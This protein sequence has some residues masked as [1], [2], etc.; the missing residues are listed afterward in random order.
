MSTNQSLKQKRQR[1]V[2]LTTSGL[3]KLQQARAEAEYFENLGQKYILADLSERC[4]LDSGTVSKILAAEQGVDKQTLLRLFSAFKLE[5]HTNDYCRIGLELPQKEP[6]VTNTHQ[7]WGEAPD[8]SIFYGRQE[9]LATLQ[10]WIIKERCRLVVLLGMG[11]IGK[12][13]LAV[14]LGQQLQGEFNYLIWQSLRNAPPIDDVLA[15][16]VQFLSN[17]QETAIDLPKDVSARVGRIMHYLRASRCLLVLDNAEAILQSGKRA[18]QYR[19]GYESYSEL[20]RQVG[21]VTHQSCLVLTSREKPEEITAQ[22]GE[23]L[24]VRSFQL[25]GLKETEGQQLLAAKGLAVR[26]GIEGTELVKYYSGN[27]LALKIAATSIRELFLDNI[28]AFLTQGT[29]VF[30]EIRKLLEQQFNRLSVLEEQVM[31]WM[32]IA[33]EPILLLELQEDIVLP[34][35]KA[36]LLEAIQSLLRRSLIESSLAGFSQQAVVMEYVT[37]RLVEQIYKEITSGQ[38]ESL[39]SHALIKASAKEYIRVNQVRMILEPIAGR[40]VS[41]FN[42]KKNVENQLK[43][44]LSKLRKQFATSP[45]YGGGNLINLLSQLEIDLS[46]YDFS[47]LS[48]WQAYLANLNLHQVNFAYADLAKSIFAETFG[49]VLSI[50]LSSDGKLLASGD[51]CGEIHLW[52]VIDGQKLFTWKGHASWIIEVT[53]SPDGQILASGGFDKIV[54]LWDVNTGQCLKVLEG[55]TGYILTIKF[56]S[57]SQTLVSSSS[58]ELLINL[59]NVKTG[60]HLKTLQGHTLTV[61]SVTLSSNGQ[62]LFSGSGDQTIRQWDIATGH[63]LKI[64]Q[65][66]TDWVWSVCLSPDD[67]T[68]ASGSAD[69]TVRLWDTNT[70]ECIKVLQGHNQLVYSV[71]FNPNGKIIASGSADCTVRLWDTNTGKCL[72]VLLGHT[73]KVW[74][75]TFSPDGSILFS[76]SEDQTIKLWDVG[77]GRCLKTLQGYI[78]WVWA[79]TFSPNGQTLASGNGDGAIR[80]WDVSTGQ[81]LRTIHEHKSWIWSITFSPDGQT[82]LS[83]SEDQTVRLWDIRTGQCLKILRECGS[84]IASATFSPDGQTIAVACNDTNVWLV[85]VR[86]G[87]CLRKLQGHTQ[88]VRSVSFSSVKIQGNEQHP[89][90]SKEENQVLLSCGQDG[91]IKLWNAQTGKCFKTL[92]LL[93]L[94]ENM[95]ITGVTGL[96]KATIETLKA[97]GAFEL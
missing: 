82:L 17:Q 8:V 52:S 6:V 89:I 5:L 78:D 7:D 54:K 21:E 42:S 24:P 61:V 70:G 87:R 35:S 44:V 67:K 1:G 77:T 11:G 27:P 12:T 47:H 30:N 69:C 64:L 85:N 86:T 23:M 4:G 75:I 25:V 45:G 60:Q 39:M 76:G 55:H 84:S 96:T 81:C 56:S 94:Y 46:S 62:T 63:C 72:K 41:T 32:A 28:T 48:I 19:I 34:V 93:R 37:E 3:Q 40:L 83:G 50:A 2:R 31:Y 38:V 43:Q 59:W 10:K 49:N 16:L 65:G 53:F 95:N 57:D 74:S 33:R 80:L 58:S 18:G 9:E 36:E 29:A 68:L 88:S 26:D 97:L 92:K 91:T 51:T 90:S 73:K 15:H 22:E 14:K 20:L 79:A 71:A 13:A 66:H